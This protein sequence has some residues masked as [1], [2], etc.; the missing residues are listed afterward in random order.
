MR[1]QAINLAITM[2][3]MASLHSTSDAKIDR[4]FLG[5]AAESVP[6]T[7]TRGD[8][9]EMCDIMTEM[10]NAIEHIFYCQPSSINVARKKL[11]K[12][13]S[14]AIVTSLVNKESEWAVLSKVLNTLKIAGAVIPNS[15]PQ[16]LKDVGLTS[17]YRANR[18]I[19]AK[20]NLPQCS[21]ATSRQGLSDYIKG[22]DVHHYDT[23]WVESIK[24][25]LQDEVSRATNWAKSIKVSD[26]KR[27]S[28]TVLKYNYSFI[29]VVALAA[30][31]MCILNY[32]SEILAG[33]LTLATIGGSLAFPAVGAASAAATA[34]RTERGI[35]PRAV[36]STILGLTM[37]YYALSDN[38]EEATTITILGI[39]L[40]LLALLAMS[41]GSGDDWDIKIITILIL[42][43]FCSYTY[44]T[45]A[46]SR[47]WAESKADRVYDIV[48][49][50]ASNIYKT[51]VDKATETVQMAKSVI[52]PKPKPWYEVLLDQQNNLAFIGCTLAAAAI[53]FLDICKTWG[54]HVYNSARVFY[55]TRTARD[56]DPRFSMQWSNHVLMSPLLTFHNGIIVACIAVG[57]ATQSGQTMIG[58]YS[59]AWV[60]A[61]LAFKIIAEDGYISRGMQSGR[62]PNSM[63]SDYSFRIGSMEDPELGKQLR[64]VAT[65][66]SGTGVAIVSYGMTGPIGLTA[67]ALYCATIYQRPDRINFMLTIAYTGTNLVWV[68]G[69]VQGIVMLG[70]I[71]NEIRLIVGTLSNTPPVEEVVT[72]DRA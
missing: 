55:G 9:Q 23:T 38:H 33:L 71:A 34:A 15:A 42:A 31:I 27:T 10:S 68:P 24:G 22:E 3:L 7:I 40:A 41:K 48:T 61:A 8:K 72:P 29:E 14:E 62:A 47:S 39:G 54:N 65:F 53:F 32:K 52:T 60:L 30:V 6:E 35:S 64:T 12:A 69:L 19:C 50:M 66:L 56:S 2:I 58:S 13:R 18:I 57:F 5:F 70:L 45:K 4:E 25:A 43:T 1:N 17:D 59:V 67:A 20:N 49:N 37:I 16:D 26:I 11:L 51:S 46:N 63:T 28:D 21:F 36:S 44:W